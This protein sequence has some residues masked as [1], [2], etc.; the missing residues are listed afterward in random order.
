M[1]TDEYITHL[2]KKHNIQVTFNKGE[3][4]IKA[5]KEALTKEIVEDIKTRKKELI[6]FFETVEEGT[7][8]HTIPVADKRNEYPLSSVQKRL[9][10]L[11]EFDPASLAY[12]APRM[13]RVQG[14]VDKDRLNTAFKKLVAHH[15]ILRT[16][17]DLANEGPVQRVVDGVTF[18]IAYFTTD[19]ADA[20][21]IIKNFIQPFDLSK[22]PLLRV[23]L[24]TTSEQEH[25][26]V[27]DMHHIITD[28]VSS[29]ILTSDFMVLYN[30]QQLQDVQLTY[31]DFAVWQQS[32]EQQRR[33]M[34]QKDFWMKQ[35]S[36]EPPR[37]ELPADF[38]R[39][40]V[41]SYEGESITVELPNELVKR[42]KVFADKAGVTLFMVMMAVTNVLLAKLGNQEDVVVG[43]PTAGRQHADLE[44]VIGMFINTLPVRNYPRNDLPFNEFL[45]AV[46]AVTLACFHHQS[47]PYEQL[48]DDLK[49]KRDLSHNPLFDIMFAYQNF[50]APDLQIPDLTLTSYASKHVIAQFDILLSIYESTDELVLRCDYSK[51]LFKK[52]TIKRFITY[53]K[54]IMNAVLNNA[55]IKIGQIDLLDEKEKQQLVHDFNDTKVPYPVTKT[56]VDVFEEQVRKIP[57]NTA[58]IYGDTKITYQELKTGSDKIAAYLCEV[59]KIK[60]GDLVGVML[61]REEQ[62][63]PVIFGILKSGAAYVPI[64]PNFPTDRIQSIIEDSKLKLLVTRDDHQQHS[65]MTNVAIANLDKEAEAIQAQQLNRKEIVIRSNQLAY[66]I[67]TS[68]STGK[69]KGVMI[70][71]HSVINRIA[72]MQK[73]YPLTEKD[74]L[75][76][77]TPIVFDVSVWE[78]FWWSFAGA[79]LCLLK[80]GEEK[81][82]EEITKTI[83]K[84]S[85]TTIHFVPPMLS[86]FLAGLD[87]DFNYK[88]LKSLKQVFSSGEALK[89]EHVSLFGNTLHKNN[90]TRLINLYGPTEAT[91]DVSYYECEFESACSTVPIGKPI[92]NISLY[93]LNETR[94]LVPVGVSGELYIAGVGVGRGYLNN[95]EL[96]QDKFVD[97]P[98]APGEKMYRTGD[99]ARWLPSGDVEYLGRID[100]QVKLRGFRI[101]LGEIENQ[102][103]N[104]AAIHET[105][106]LAKDEGDNKFL[107]AYYVSEKEIEELELR[108]HLLK[109]L[110]E[111]MVPSYFVHLEDMPL[112]V[113][114]KINRKAL[115]QPKK[116]DALECLAPANELEE[117]VLRMWKEVLDSDAIGTN[118]DFFLVG[119][120]SLKLIKLFKLLNDQFPNVIKVRNLFENRTIISTATYIQ[121]H[122]QVT[123]KPERRKK[124]IVEF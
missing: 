101:E 55:N 102:L 82:P 63:I 24:I 36:E 123:P 92:D 54:K 35:F 7:N 109:A 9:H 65:I 74:V 6:Q 87:E 69:P 2:R 116:A 59:K 27:I 43:T 30:N 64:D 71:H 57:D 97:N 122:T 28:G 53:F 98:F 111:Y 33:L 66:V 108:N 107:V 1:R 61:N 50:A 84:N 95:Q 10:F 20:D 38:T 100:N 12:N 118:E 103:S 120:N 106:V 88:E 68:G 67:Y 89:T 83:A 110:P 16:Y 40:L 4:K 96:T 11:Y 15:D 115:P 49:V 86:V 80:P 8:S 94:Q 48:I 47:Y 41:Q 70:E 79:S 22:A 3:L 124:I 18:E 52:E 104:H 99:L 26:L 32:E 37:L 5:E 42:L 78:L 31:K 76:Q 51:A 81:E 72:W 13:I 113:N 85:V 114:G 77:K 45:A 19:H 29:D 90:G 121:E 119:G 21:T 14:A 62:L 75:L 25:V 91:V 56:L 117:Q 73:Q 58:L 46:K 112:T 105:V 93:V 39:P 23:A 17:F 44:K 60:S 34:K